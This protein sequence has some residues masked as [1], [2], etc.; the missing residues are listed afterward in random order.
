M[1]LSDGSLLADTFVK[2]FPQPTAIDS[3]PLHAPVCGSGEHR[4]RRG[5]VV[6]AHRL[7]HGNAIASTTDHRRHGAL[8]PA[9]TDVVHCPPAFRGFRWVLDIGTTCYSPSIRDRVFGFR[10]QI[11]DGRGFGYGYAFHV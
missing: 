7:F 4:H 11:F 3:I 5:P 9:V 1:E 8:C 10:G 2:E 6:H